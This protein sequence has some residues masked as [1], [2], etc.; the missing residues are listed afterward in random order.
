M[1]IPKTNR[2]VLFLLVCVVFAVPRAHARAGQWT[3]VATPI[4]PRDNAGLVSLLDGSVLLIGGNIPTGGA[5]V[6]TAERYANGAWSDAGVVPSDGCPRGPVL[7]PN[8]KVLVANGNTAAIYDPD[9]SAWTRISP[10]LTPRTGHFAALLSNGKVLVAGGSGG[11][12]S[13]PLSSENFDPDT[14]TWTAGASIS[15]SPQATILLPNGKLLLVK[16]G[17]DTVYLFDPVTSFLRATGRLITDR[18]GPSLRFLP[19]GQILVAGGN[20]TD[21]EIYNIGAERWLPTGS[22]GN[23]PGGPVVSLSSGRVLIAGGRAATLGP[24]MNS[25][26]LYDPVTGTWPSIEAMNKARSGF[27]GVLL[28]DNRVLVV[29][30]EL[31]GTAEGYDPGISNP[32]PALSAI[33]PSQAGADITSGVFLSGANFLPN[34]VVRAG[35]VRLVTVYMGSTQ[36]LAFIPRSLATPGANLQITVTNSGPG[37]STSGS[38][39]VS[40]TPPNPLPT[41]SRVS[42]SS[43]ARVPTT[44]TT[45]TVTG[46]NFIPTSVVYFNQTLLQT[47]F[48]NSTT[49]SAVVPASAIAPGSAG[50]IVFNS[51]PGGGSTPPLAFVTVGRW[52]PTGTTRDNRSGS[53]ATILADG[54]VLV[55]GGGTSAEIFDPNTNTWTAAASMRLARTGHTATLLPNGKVLAVGGTFAAGRDAVELAEIYDPAT[56]SWSATGSMSTGRMDHTATILADGRVLVAGGGLS[57]YGTPLASAELYDP[58]TGNWAVTGSMSVARYFHAASRLPDQ[59]VVVTGGERSYFDTNYQ[60]SSVESYDPLSGTWRALASMNSPRGEVFAALL[61]DGR[62]LVAGGRIQIGNSFFSLATAEI[63]DP[64]TNVWTATSARN[65]AGGGSTSAPLST[66]QVL[67]FSSAASEIYDPE[68]G[69]WIS[70]AP[71]SESRTRGIVLLDGRVLAFGGDSNTTEIYEPAPS[72]PIRRPFTFVD[73]G[74][75]SFV[76]SGVSPEVSVGYARIQPEGT[77]STPAGLAIFGFRENGVL[78]TESGIPA[79]RLLQSGRVYAEMNGLVNTGFAIANPN[80]TSATISFYFTNLAGVDSGGNSFVLPANE[81]ISVFLNQ[82]PFNGSIVRGTF[83]FASS[84]PVAAAALRGSVNERGD[85]LIATQPVI[86]LDAQTSTNTLVFPTFADGGGWTTQVVLVNPSNFTAL[87]GTLQF[88]NQAGG[89]AEVTAN[90]QLT[91][92]FTYSIPPGSSAIVQTAGLPSSPVSG[93]VRA[94]PATGTIAPSGFVIFSFSNGGIKVTEAGVAALPLSTAFRM[95]AEYSAAPSWIQSGVA[96]ANPSSSSTTV[97]LEITRLDGTP[98]GLTGTLVIPPNGQATSFLREIPGLAGLTAPFQGVVRVSSPTP[99]SAM[100]LRGRYNERQDFLYTTTPPVD[101]N[102]PPVFTPLY[103][104]QIVDSG[105]YSTQFILFSGSPGQASTG[106]TRIFSS[107]GEALNWQLR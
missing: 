86:D 94:I 74:A 6:V 97:T 8:G 14:L 15:V 83:S 49:L 92:A 89:P 43:L 100:G 60:T 68:T 72:I 59:S 106:T 65:F 18:G 88:L 36:L 71:T 30:G 46:T 41:L 55:C 4:T 105:G 2:V 21:P 52:T 44:A 98:T 5:C 29:G 102:A 40:V 51:G 85:F 58:A 16:G 70:T 54:R 61:F 31:N 9:T 13:G 104:P 32:S 78:V 80:S 95:Y 76:S 1:N 64:R 57:R 47:T 93:S 42:P 34:S 20:R 91:S 63:Y 87:T 26:D 69:T 81:K 22:S 3:M 101:E 79:S 56:N 96:V 73:R 35:N 103:F 11:P 53:A 12:N 37:G 62:L 27:P 25:A 45:I 39:L 84:V 19:D 66:G 77:A 10:M 17:P 33:S 99:I 90:G 75:V 28:D 107:T 48:V 50:I 23:R 38:R 82:A 7:L 67:V 24:P